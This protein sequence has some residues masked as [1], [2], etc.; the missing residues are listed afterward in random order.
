MQSG[1]KPLESA[2]EYAD[3]KRNY[4]RLFVEVVDDIK[5]CHAK[6]E[7]V[8]TTLEIDYGLEIDGE[9]DMIDSAIT[10]VMKKINKLDEEL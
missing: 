5:Y 10:E 8:L 2:E 4:L 6:L 3:R 9:W 7:Y 1:R